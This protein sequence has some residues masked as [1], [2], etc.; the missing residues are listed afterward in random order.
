[1][2]ELSILRN[3]IFARHGH[4][5]QVRW[6]ADYFNDQPWYKPQDYDASTISELDRANAVT[7]ARYESSLTK[8]ELKARKDALEKQIDR[9][10]LWSDERQVEFLLLSR[11]LGESTED[12]EWVADKITPLDNPAM[13]ERLLKVDELRNMSR[14]DLR[15][16]RNMIFARRGRP[17]KS[18]LLQDYFGRM[19]WYKADPKY[20]DNRLTKVDR[21]NIQLVTSVE[22]E[23]GGPLSEA[24]H[25]EAEWAM[26]A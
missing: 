8:E 18:E 6:I 11:A 26:A 10:N 3:T 22:K 14:R 20:S 1:M 24:E 15:V 21:A 17:F 16:L 19:H 2:R 7:I 9:D 13:L 25:E 5:F 23:L 12:V 4:I